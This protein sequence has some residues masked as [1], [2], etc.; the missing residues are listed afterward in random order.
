[1]VSP[2][3][4]APVRVRERISIHSPSGARKKYRLISGLMK[5][6]SRMSTI[7]QR[8]GEVR[9]LHGLQQRRVGLAL[10]HR[11]SSR[12]QRRPVRAFP[13]RPRSAAPKRSE[14][15]GSISA[16]T[17]AEGCRS[18]A[19]RRRR[20][21][22]ERIG[23]GFVALCSQQC[24]TA[25]DLGFAVRQPHLDG[26][27]FRPS[28]SIAVSRP[29]ARKPAGRHRSKVRRRTAKPELGQPLDLARHQRRGRAALQHV[30][31][32]GPAGMLGGAKQ[33]AFRPENGGHCRA[34]RF[35]SMPDF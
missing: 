22:G 24:G 30:R 9:R 21:C 26:L 1:M 19:A 31:R 15:S 3:L 5:V 34:P 20:K 33:G 2:A 35:K 25:A 4:L 27:A 13:A 11:Q 23:R 12:I 7:G 28:R 6:H 29:K 14:N 16:Q 32:P 10:D 17:Q 8:R 18:P